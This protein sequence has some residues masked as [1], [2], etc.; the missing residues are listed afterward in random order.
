MGNGQDLVGK[1]KDWC[2][3][4]EMA[5]EPTGLVWVWTRHIKF[6]MK[7]ILQS[8][9]IHACTCEHNNLLLYVLVEM[10]VMLMMRL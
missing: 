1:I 6:I 8:S 3:L 2:V 4:G 10:I 9:T 7:T 5:T